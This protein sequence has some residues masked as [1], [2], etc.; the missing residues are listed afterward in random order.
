MSKI[1]N[2]E[3]SINQLVIQVEID[4]EGQIA[5]HNWTVEEEIGGSLPSDEVAT[6]ELKNMYKIK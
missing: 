2:I 6:Q 1:L 4:D 3:R 5:T